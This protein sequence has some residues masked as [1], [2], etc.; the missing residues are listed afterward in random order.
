MSNVI[1]SD[2]F[3]SEIEVDCL[4]IGGGAAGLTAALA[5][6]EAG[7]SVLIAER[8]AELAGSTALSSGLILSL[9]HI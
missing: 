5:A 7:D 8:D 4:I 3:D 6:T 2:G 1:V 9:I